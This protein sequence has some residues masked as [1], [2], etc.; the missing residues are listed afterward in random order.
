M[1]KRKVGGDGPV[2]RLQLVYPDGEQLTFDAGSAF[3][4]DIVAAIKSEILARG[5]GMF[6][7]EAHVAQD[8]EDGVKAALLSLKRESLRVV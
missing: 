2:F 7:G 3:E 6:R 8:I 1:K 4:R 5:V